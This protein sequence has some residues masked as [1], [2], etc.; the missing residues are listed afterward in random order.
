MTKTKRKVRICKASMETQDG[1]VPCSRESGHYMPH[2]TNKLSWY[3]EDSG[4]DL[5]KKYAEWTKPRGRDAELVKSPTR[6]KD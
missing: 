2:R 1:S 3:N 6:G 4:E 5:G